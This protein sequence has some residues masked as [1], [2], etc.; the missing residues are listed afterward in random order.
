MEIAKGEGI[1]LGKKSIYPTLLIYPM[2]D[3]TNHYKEIPYIAPIFVIEHNNKFQIYLDP[4][5]QDNYQD[6][7]TQSFDG[8]MIAQQ[9]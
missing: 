2:N 6:K 8:D 3:I 4:R 9:N 7:L 1:K 5:I